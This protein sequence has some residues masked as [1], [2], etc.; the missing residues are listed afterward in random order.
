TFAAERSFDID[1]YP[2]IE[3]ADADRFNVLDQPYFFEGAAA[4]LRPDR[5]TFLESYKFD[6][7]PATDD[8][9]YFFDFFRWRALPELLERRSLGG[10]ALLDW[11]YLILVA[12]LV[13]ALALSI[14]LILAPLASRHRACDKVAGRG[15][16]TLYF[17]AI[18]LA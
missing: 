2:G 18:G 5:Q 10:A 1:Y 7:F 16:V 3:R 17:A 12:T 8:R 13:Q 15:R 11:G 6:L 9:P 14:V 4:L